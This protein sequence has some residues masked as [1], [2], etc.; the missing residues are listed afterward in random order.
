MKQTGVFIVKNY[1]CVL[2]DINVNGKKRKINESFEEYETQ[3]LQNLVSNGYLQEL[4][5]NVK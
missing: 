2:Q 5:K 3:E 4:K 1:R